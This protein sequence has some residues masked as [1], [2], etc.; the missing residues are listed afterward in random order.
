MIIYLVMIEILGGDDCFL[1]NQS[2]KNVGEKDWGMSWFP[3]FYS[4]QDKNAGHTIKHNCRNINSD[5]K[6]KK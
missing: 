5:H 4:C 3:F 6:S 2:N 1:S